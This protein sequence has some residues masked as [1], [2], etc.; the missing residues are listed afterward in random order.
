MPIELR[1]LGEYKT[2]RIRMYEGTLSGTRYWLDSLIVRP[3]AQTFQMESRFVWS[4]NFDDIQAQYEKD[5]KKQK[6]IES[7]A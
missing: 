3:V 1:T 7:A 5:V 2:I 6:R 4:E